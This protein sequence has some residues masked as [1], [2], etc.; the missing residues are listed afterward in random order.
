VQTPD[1]PE[2]DVWDQIPPHITSGVENKYTSEAAIAKDLKIDKGADEPTRRD[3]ARLLWKY[4]SVVGEVMAGNVPGFW[5]TIPLESDDPIIVPPYPTR[6]PGMTEW[7]EE[8]IKELLAAGL[9]EPSTSTKYATQ[10]N[11]RITRANS[12]PV[13]SVSTTEPSIRKQFSIHTRCPQPK[14]A[15]R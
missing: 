8:K 10:A 9:I 4:K 12:Q 1:E 13:G 14:S 5:H 6:D 3:V 2:G 15:W 11:A 7:L